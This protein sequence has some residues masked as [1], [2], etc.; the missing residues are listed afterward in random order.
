MGHV[1]VDNGRLQGYHASMPYF[2][3]L[4]FV[5]QLQKMTSMFMST[6]H[7]SSSMQHMLRMCLHG[8]KTIVGHPQSM[9]CAPCSSARKSTRMTKEE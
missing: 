3:L 9:F 6:T 5:I 1:V 4:L 2:S 7:L 8:G